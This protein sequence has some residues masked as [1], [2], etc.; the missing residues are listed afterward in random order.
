MM[1]W[2]PVEPYGHLYSYTTVCHQV[3]AAFDVPYTVVLVEIDEFPHI[4][5]VGNLQGEPDL[6]IGMAMIARFELL[7]NGAALPQWEVA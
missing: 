5:L 7:E 4:R 6:R 2:R 3:H 1:T